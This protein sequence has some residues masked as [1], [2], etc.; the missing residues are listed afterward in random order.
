MKFS[1]YDPTFKARRRKCIEQANRFCVRCETPHRSF[2]FTSDNEVYIVY[3]HAAHVFAD[4]K[5]NPNAP[6]I[7]LCPTCHWHYDH[8]QTEDDW[9]FVGTVYQWFI[10]QKG[11]IYGSQ[12]SL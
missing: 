2:A 11:A 4:D 5:Q 12:E 8:P 3:L 1:K 6:L 7:A 10:E 9:A